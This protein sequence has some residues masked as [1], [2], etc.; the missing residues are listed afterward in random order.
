MKVNAI[1]T[2]HPVTIDAKQPLSEAAKLMRKQHVGTLVVTCLTPTG[3]EVYGIVTDRDLVIDAMSESGTNASLQ[4]V[5]LAHTDLVIVEEHTELEDAIS[6]MHEGG[7]R[8]LLVSDKD[9][10]LCGLLSID[11]V[12]QAL[13]QQLSRVAETIRAGRDREIGRRPVVTSVI[14]RPRLST[15][16]AFAWPQTRA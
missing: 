8:R 10:R 3:T 16:G 5:D 13:A 7:V 1:C 14:P 12:I 4:V 2:R 11:D 15:V 6:V 9:Q